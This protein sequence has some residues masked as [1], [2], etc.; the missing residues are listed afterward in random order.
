MRRPINALGKDGY[1]I[2]DPL[3]MQAA[4]TRPLKQATRNYAN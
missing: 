2:A 4:N 1:P 3:L